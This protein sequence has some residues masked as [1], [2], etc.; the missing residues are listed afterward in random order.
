MAQLLAL[1]E[2]YKQVT[3]KQFPRAPPSAAQQKAAP[4]K[5]NIVDMSAAADTLVVRVTEQGDTVRQLKAS[6]ADKV[7]ETFFMRLTKLLL[8]VCKGFCYLY[9]PYNTE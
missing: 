6:G 8:E 5:E 3:G 7:G 4:V 9:V 1:K 2:E